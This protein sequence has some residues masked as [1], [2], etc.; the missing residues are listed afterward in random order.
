MPK[1]IPLNPRI[2]RAEGNK[3]GR[4]EY[5][6]SLIE[7]A[8][9]AFGMQKSGQW[10]LIFENDTRPNGQVNTIGGYPLYR[11]YEAIKAAREAAE[12]FCARPV[13]A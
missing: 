3:G 4:Q 10:W 7:D 6:E 9:K 2:V 12:A 8:H 13:P 5:V 1:K 11:R